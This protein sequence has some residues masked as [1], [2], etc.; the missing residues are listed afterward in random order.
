MN[1]NKQHI[2]NLV[3]DFLSNQITHDSLKELN[4]WVNATDDN[5]KHF[6]ELK[7]AWVLSAAK[8][9]NDFSAESGYALFQNRVNSNT[10]NI[11]A[12]PKYSLVVKLITAAMILI[13]AISIW[14]LIQHGVGNRSQLTSSLEVP[15]GSILKVT[16]P[17]NSIAWINADTRLEYL[18]DFGIKN[19]NIK[20]DGEGYFEVTK[21]KN[22]PFIVTTSNT[23]TEV[24]GTKFKVRN[25]QEDK[26]ITVAL[27]E[28]AIKFTGDSDEPYYLSPNELITFDKSNKAVERKKSNIA[29][30]IGWVN[31]KLFFDEESFEEIVLTLERTFDVKIHVEN[32]ALKTMKFYGDF[33][34][35]ANNLVQ[36]MEIMATT[37]KFNYKYKI[38]KNEIFIY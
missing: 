1:N 25:Y 30:S 38:E 22:L 2:E 33:E 10:R 8:N 16:L 23:E 36:I 12:T 26:V 31:N 19:R 11:S 9:Q 18:S 34:I 6:E 17:D 14:S 28:G 21:N 27:F 20:I 37:N 5:R 7:N 29:Q 24:L 32:E 13:T 4:E 3:A 35:E 15:R